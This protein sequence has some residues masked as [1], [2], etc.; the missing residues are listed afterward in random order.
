M[1]FLK[2]I[3]L[4]L[5]VI[6]TSVFI[7][8]YFKFGYHTLP[9]MPEN[10][11]PLRFENDV[12]AIMVGTHDK[13]YDTPPRTYIAAPLQNIPRWYKNSWPFCKMPDSNEI[14]KADKLFPPEPGMRLEAVCE[15]NA[16]GK[17]IRTAFIYS[18]PDL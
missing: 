11:F 2:I 9:E 13:R 8:D 6:I 1:R 15:L 14:K 4:S 7:Y 5:L 17:I 12:R 3:L 16:D 10:S 18:V